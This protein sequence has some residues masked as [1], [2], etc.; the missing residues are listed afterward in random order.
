MDKLEVLRGILQEMGR[1]MVAYSGGV[2]SSLLLWVGRDVL[3]EGNVIAVTAR[4]ATYPQAELEAA[5]GITQLLGVRH[6]V[7]ESEELDIPEFQANPVDRCYYCKK[8]LF[9]KLR[10]L[11]AQE[12]IDHVI[13]GT[14]YDDLGDHRPGMRAAQEMGIRSP[15]KEARLTKEEIRHYSRRLGLPNWDKPSYACLSSRF[16]YGEAITREKLQRVE[17]AEEYLRSQG[18][19]QLRVRHHNHIARIEIERTD[20]YRL[21]QDELL[22]DIVKELKGLGFTYITLDL[23]GYRSGSMNEALSKH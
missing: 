20:F 13:D 5:R 10:T 17:R 18:F 9:S 14:N 7:I 22:A 2:D 12:G 16:P 11:A 23:E 21:L 1:V 19:R 15:L 6:L 3:G 4:S 8:E